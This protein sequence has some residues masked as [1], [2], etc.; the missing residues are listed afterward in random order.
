MA[1]KKAEKGK[2][3]KASRES[4]INETKTFLLVFSSLLVDLFT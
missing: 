1:D 3:E 4:K 2:I